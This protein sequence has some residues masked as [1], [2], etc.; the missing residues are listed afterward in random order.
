MTPVMYNK[1]Y[2][3]LPPGAAYHDGNKSTFF[4]KYIWKY[5]YIHKGSK[6]Q[7]HVGR[8]LKKQSLLHCTKIQL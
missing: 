3:L 5:K 1:S 4:Y 8:D 2:Q 7:Q 6:K